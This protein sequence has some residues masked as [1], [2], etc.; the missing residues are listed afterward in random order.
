MAPNFKKGREYSVAFRLRPLG[1][2]LTG[3]PK[4]EELARQDFSEHYDD[5]FA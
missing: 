5:L 3:E 2:L 1:L 4:P